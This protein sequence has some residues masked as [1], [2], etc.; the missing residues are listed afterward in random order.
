MFNNLSIKK[1]KVIM[2]KI[3]EDN[4]GGLFVKDSKGS[5]KIEGR[6][7]NICTILR[8]SFLYGN[9]DGEYLNS[10]PFGKVI[11]EYDGDVMTV[12]T[13]RMGNAGRSL[14]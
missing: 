7:Y 6:R 3:L 10:S 2:I 8:D 12:Y 14:L 13:K 5:Y 11:A 4:S 1:G 9:E